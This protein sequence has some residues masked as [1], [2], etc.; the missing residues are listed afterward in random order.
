MTSELISQ[1]KGIGKVIVAFNLLDTQL[2]SFIG[3]LIS[4]DIGTGQIVTSQINSVA[5]RLRL[6]FILYKYKASRLEWFK[7]PILK[8]HFAMRNDLVRKAN[9]LMKEAEKINEIRNKIIHSTWFQQ[10]RHLD[11]YGKKAQLTGLRIKPEGSPT[12]KSGKVGLNYQV[13]SFTKKELDIYVRRIERFG[14]ELIKLR[15]ETEDLA[16][17]KT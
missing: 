11:Q 13:V 14:V 2:N 8:E 9:L 10:Q 17:K 16:N 5:N 7:P 4:N 12:I 1:Y 6:F 15:K 3:W